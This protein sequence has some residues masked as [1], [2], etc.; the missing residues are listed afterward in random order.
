M[1]EFIDATTIEDAWRQAMYRLFEVGRVYTIDTGSFEGHKR[2][3]FYPLVVINIRFPDVVCDFSL[4]GKGIPSPVSQE[5][6]AQYMTK[7][8]VP[9]KADDEDYT[10]G[11]FIGVQIGEVIDKLKKGP[12]TNQATI[13]VGNNDSIHLNDPPCLKVI[14][15]RLFN[16][17]HLDMIV[18]FR[19]WDLWA[20]FPNNLIGL[21]NLRMAI[22][23]SLGIVAYKG[24]I[25][26][27]SKGLHLYDYCWELAETLNNKKL[28]L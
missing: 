19:S 11:Q 2:L 3:E 4:E 25:I 26:A 23:D 8:L 10:Y 7:L 27:M 16:K 28:E 17:N 18:Y 20:G 15:F 14:D 24:S 22:C 21:E 12:G 5:Y 6:I 13:T 1:I 9:E